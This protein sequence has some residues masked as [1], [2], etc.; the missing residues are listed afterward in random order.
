VSRPRGWPAALVALQHDDFRLLWLG[1]L[2][3][4]AGS[5]MQ[6][7]A[8]LWHV[9]LLAP[10]DQKGLALGL[11]GLTRVVP[12]VALSLI[13]GVIADAHDRRRVMFVTQTALILVAGALALL[14]FRGEITLLQLYALSALGAAATTFDGPAR[15]ALVPRLV[16]REHFPNAIGLNTIM[17]QAASVLGPALAGIVIA[18]GGPAWAYA[19][20][21]ASF[22]AVI[23]ALLAM[24]LP[25]GAAAEPGERSDVSLRAALDGLRFTFSQPLIRS[26]M[27]L[28]FF[29]T[30]FSSATALLPI[31]AQDVLR[32]GPTGYGALYAAPAVGALVAGAIMVPLAERIDRRG[33]T[34][35]W[36]VAAYGA[37]TIVFGLSRDF[38]LTFACLAATGAA[39]T[40]SMVLRNIIRQL[41]TPDSLRGRMTSVNMMFFM[42]GPQLGE[43][44]AGLVAQ[45]FGA[46]ASVVTGG[47]GCLVATAWTAWRTPELRADR[48]RSAPEVEPRVSPRVHNS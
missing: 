7:A 29:A 10:P 42:G 23:A 36:A 33:P 25:G 12:I 5:M 40:V 30:F 16:P 15:Q 26:T 35:L 11:V 28:D 31:F 24:K 41:S 13:S 20:N 45:G 46:P 47:V 17:F 3:S 32:V 27:L 6:S 18:A 2:V 21:A 38:A 9:A 14:T 22:L 39:D 37:A 4:N 48:T 43:L 19:L 1:Q 34:L 8:I 44:E